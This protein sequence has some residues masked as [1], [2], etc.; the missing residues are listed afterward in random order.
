VRNDLDWHRKQTRVPRGISPK[1]RGSA[2]RGLPASRTPWLALASLLA[3]CNSCA[4]AQPTGEQ[5]SR[6]RAELRRGKGA[7]V[8]ER[9]DRDPPELGAERPGERELSP[10]PRWRARSDLYDAGELPRSLSLR[11]PAAPHIAREVEVAS[12]PQFER[13]SQTPGT[14]LVVTRALRGEALVKGSNVEV[15]MRDG[16]TIER[17]RIAHGQKRIRLRGGRYGQI[18]FSHPAQFQPVERPRPDW[19]IEDVIIDGVRVDAPRSAIEVFG[20]R[21]AVLNS[22]IR[23]QTYSLWSGPVL[24]IGSEDVLIAG[25]RM[26]SAGPEATLRLVDVLRSVTVDNLLRNEFKHTYRVHGR[27]DLAYA[28]RNAFIHTGVMFGTMPNDR[29]GRIWFEDNTFFHRQNDLFHPGPGGVARLRAVGNKAH[30]A[31]FRCFCCEP[32]SADWRLSR[33]QLLPYREPPSF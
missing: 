1:F 30:T 32:M 4:Q 22:D 9:K 8:P 17:L 18:L 5:A 6:P 3:A 7:A 19:L 13:A 33:N 14:R 21:V 27:S 12:V 26:S 31:K 11:W 10:E 29:V 23:A 16:V 28:G 24:G 2:S 20:K 15:T 25:N